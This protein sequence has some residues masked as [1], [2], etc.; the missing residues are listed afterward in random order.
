[1]VMGMVDGCVF[2][3]LLLRN[4]VSFFRKRIFIE[5]C[6]RSCMSK[7]NLWGMLWLNP[8]LKPG[9]FFSFLLRFLWLEA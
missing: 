2:R 7:R 6:R 5:E 4:E 9:S 3:E 1:M 8:S